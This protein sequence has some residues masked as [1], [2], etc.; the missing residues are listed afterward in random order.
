M[1]TKIS[2][3]ELNKYRLEN[4]IAFTISWFKT[5]DLDEYVINVTLYL[6]R[7]GLDTNKFLKTRIIEN[8]KH[9]YMIIYILKR[10]VTLTQK[11]INIIDNKAFVGDIISVERIY[12]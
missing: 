8:E 10:G 3:K 12:K 9:E 5:N 11:E 4:R 7:L 1:Y 2:Y 6:R